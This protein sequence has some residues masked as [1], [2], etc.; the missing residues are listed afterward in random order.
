M[1]NKPKQTCCPKIIGVIFVSK[2][3]IKKYGVEEALLKT[4]K[5]LN[6]K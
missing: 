3:L 2:Y 6:K 4:V 5:K 1:T